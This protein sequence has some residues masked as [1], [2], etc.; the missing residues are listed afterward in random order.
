ML[1]AVPE[2]PAQVP[3]DARVSYGP[4]EEDRE[5]E[6][7]VRIVPVWRTDPDGYRYFSHFRQEKVYPLRR[8]VGWIWGG[9]RRIVPRLVG[10]EDAIA[11]MFDAIDG[12][13]DEPLPDVSV[14]YEAVEEIE[15]VMGYSE[16]EY[17][18]GAAS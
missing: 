9:K 5:R 10:P 15:P 18:R 1:A 8:R 7:E 14:T 11:R 17:M 6:P 3:P 16:W 12:V 4:W 13:S 2:R